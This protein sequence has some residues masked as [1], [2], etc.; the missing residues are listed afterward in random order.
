M[1]H[2][3]AAVG[4]DLLGRPFATRA[5]MGKRA[6]IVAA[7]ML[8]A[9]MTLASGAGAEESAL[10]RQVV[11]EAPDRA[12]LQVRQHE[13]NGKVSWR[14]VCTGPCTTTVQHGE[15]Y[16]VD[17]KGVST[18]SEFQFDSGSGPVHLKAE[19]GS[20]GELAGGVVVLGVGVLGLYFGTA[21]LD[22]REANHGS[23][24]LIVALGAAAV[25][26]GFALLIDSGRTTLDFN[27]SPS[28]SR[29]PRLN[30]GGGFAL[31]PKGIEF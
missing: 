23:A 12:E 6:S 1:S 14:T 5:G 22:V 11:F 13:G 4:I 20:P 18:S 8:A 19:V 25:L 27:A 26:G 10:R 15:L 21:L 29:V 24:G 30:L 16:R 28:V 17:G 31:T 3:A 2:V 7:I 9:S